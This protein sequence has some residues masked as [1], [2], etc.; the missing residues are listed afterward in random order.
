MTNLDGI[1]WAIIQIKKEA[2]EA[3]RAGATVEDLDKELEEQTGLDA[4]LRKILISSAQEAID[5]D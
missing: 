3:L 5:A 4:D 2:I 1:A